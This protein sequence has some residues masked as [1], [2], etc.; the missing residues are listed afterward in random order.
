M[1]KTSTRMPCR[2]TTRPRPAARMRAILGLATVLAGTAGIAGTALARDPSTL[3]DLEIPVTR[4]PDWHAADYL[5]LNT[6]S[7][8]RVD[9]PCNGGDGSTLQARF[10][11]ATPNTVLVLPANCRFRVPGTLYLRRS[12]VVLRG[13]SRTTSISRVPG[14]RSRDAERDHSGLPGQRALR[15]S[16][17]LDRRLRDRDSG[18]DGGE[19][20]RHD[21]RRLG[22][23]DGE[24]RARLAHPGQEPVCGEARLRRLDRWLA[25]FGTVGEPDPTRPRPALAV[26]PGRSIRRADD[27][28]VPAQRRHRERPLRARELEPHRAVPL[29]R[30]RWTTATSAGSRT[31]SS[32]TAATATSASRTPSAPSSAATTCRHQSVHRRRCDLPVEQGV[33][34]LQS[35]HG[36]QRLR[37]QHADAVALRPELPGRL[38]QRHRLQL[39]AR[40]QH[41]R[42]RAP[43]LPARSGHD[44]DP[45]RGQRRRLHDAVGL[46][47]RRPG[48]QQHLLPQPAPRRRQSRRRLP[49]RVA[50]AARTRAPTSTASSR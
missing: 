30:S 37:E 14:A 42:M 12:N 10:D 38:R 23:H 4:V 40:R 27:R 47:P 44:G 2:G 13:A 41:R 21:G 18:P 33:D 8:T 34:L 28:P 31:R 1:T 7:W 46:A 43:R 22:A 49:A 16:A 26:H 17:R 32:A 39:H 15:Q 9:I 3:R 5:P 25:V 20:V 45:R 50:S 35:G 24:H 6:S 36:G 11:A 19:H 48:L 29:L